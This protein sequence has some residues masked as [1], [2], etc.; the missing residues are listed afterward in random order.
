MLRPSPFYKILSEETVAVPG[1]YADV[2]DKLCQLHGECSSRDCYR[3]P[4]VFG[5]SEDGKFSFGGNVSQHLRDSRHY[6]T[7][8]YGCTYTIRTF[9]LC[10]NVAE[11]NGKTVVK[12]YNVHDCGSAVFRWLDVILDLLAI[13]L[14]ILLATV[15]PMQISAFAMPALALIGV[16]AATGNW[17]AL[18]KERENKTED[19][20]TMRQELLNHPEAVRRWDDRGEIQA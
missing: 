6:S 5:C 13:L 8:G 10:D 11:E 15:T 7:A 14:Y 18:S 3:Q 19:L 4:L 9:Y 1:K 16:F 17:L 2:V 20:V 12:L